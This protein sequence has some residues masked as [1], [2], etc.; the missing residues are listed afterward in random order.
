MRLSAMAEQASYEA[1]SPRSRLHVQAPVSMQ[2]AG[3]PVSLRHRQLGRSPG[4][5]LSTHLFHLVN[6]TRKGC[7]DGSARARAMLLQTALLPNA[8]RHLAR[9]CA[10]AHCLAG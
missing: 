7:N 5:T 3:E 2:S 9:H 10:G 6:C 8:L 1:V 4:T